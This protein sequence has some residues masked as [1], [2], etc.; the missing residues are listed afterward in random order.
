MIDSEFL[1]YMDNFKPYLL[2]G[3]KNKAEY[4]VCHA[5][6]G[7]VGDLSRSLQAAIAPY[8]DEIMAVLMEDLQVS[9]GV[10]L[11]GG[12]VGECGSR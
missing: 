3:L 7:L 5:A 1:K 9:V 11:D 6:V 4:Q 12:P 2:A 10:G 8:T